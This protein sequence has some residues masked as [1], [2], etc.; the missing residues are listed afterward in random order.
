MLSFVFE[1]SSC[2][3]LG[4]YFL[5]ATHANLRRIIMHTF[6]T[7]LGAVAIIVAVLG[8]NEAALAEHT[9]SP[10]SGI[11]KPTYAGSQERQHRTSGHHS[12]DFRL[13][14]PVKSRRG[15]SCQPAFN[16]SFTVKDRVTIADSSVKLM[17]GSDVIATL[18]KGQEVRILKVQGPWLGTSI[19]V[20]G[21]KKSG[22]VLASNAAPTAQSPKQSAEAE[23]VNTK[24]QQQPQALNQSLS[25]EPARKL[26]A[27]KDCP[28]QR[29]ARRSRLHRGSTT[30]GSDDYGF[31]FPFEWGSRSL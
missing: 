3:P 5:L 6:F 24:R 11:W 27:V 21:V 22:W 25:C 20:D 17:R 30:I 7:K 9:R 31:P 12:R 2:C 13:E 26:H 23:G 29:S 18:P 28:P 14:V 8:V 19:E 16:V 15:F 10:Y 4:L 1:S